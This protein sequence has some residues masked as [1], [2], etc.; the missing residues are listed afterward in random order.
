MDKCVHCGFCLATCPSYLEVG[1]EMDSPRGRIYLMRAAV[2]NRVALTPET[3]E[4]FDTCLGCLACETACPSG[5]DY[6]HLVDQARVH[7]EE[8]YTRPLPERL[9]RRVL[10]LV[11]PRLQV[12]SA[13]IHQLVFPLAFNLRIR[14]LSTRYLTSIC[15]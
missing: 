2:Q 8:S 4:H 9:L 7:I 12:L 13:L 10:A 11:L 1:Q 6:M 3:V 15:R 14:P 5:V